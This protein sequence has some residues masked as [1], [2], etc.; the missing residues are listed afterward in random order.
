MLWQARGEVL[1]DVAGAPLVGGGEGLRADRLGEAGVVALGGNRM[2]ASD[3]VPQALAAGQLGDGHGTKL[4][5]A[6]QLAHTA[7]AAAAGDDAGER[8]LGEKLRVL[9]EDG[10][11]TIRERRQYEKSTCAREVGATN[12]LV[13]KDSSLGHPEVTC[14]SFN[15]NELC[16]IGQMLNETLVGIHEGGCPPVQLL[17]LLQWFA[18]AKKC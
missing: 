7:A 15:N 1:E 16:G 10:L 14:N 13:P 12:Q 5:G 8:P 4:L 6:I 3:Q 17:P 2:Q 9:G 11:A 18:D